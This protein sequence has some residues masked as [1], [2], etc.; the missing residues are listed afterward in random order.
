MLSIAA[1]DEQITASIVIGG[2]L[3]FVG[4]VLTDRAAA[5][6]VAEPTPVE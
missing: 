5:R 4:V 3:I 6:S 2:A 1:L